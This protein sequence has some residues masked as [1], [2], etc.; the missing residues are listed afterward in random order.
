MDLMAR[1]A[2]FIMIESM[3]KQLQGIKSMLGF[4][5]A[6]RSHKTEKLQDRPSLDYTTPK[7]DEAIEAALAVD[8][9]K[10]KFMQELFEKA[11]P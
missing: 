2:L 9:E 8:T 1:Q 10:E 11:T 7:E 3:E 5:V 6:D 4:M